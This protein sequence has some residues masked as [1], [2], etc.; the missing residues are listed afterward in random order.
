MLFSGVAAR[1]ETSIDRAASSHNFSGMWWNDPAGSE[2]GWGINIAHQGDVMFVTWLTYDLNGKAWWLSMTANRGDGDSYAGILYETRGP[3]FN[4][5]PFDP[6]RVSLT[7]VGTATLIFSDAR[8]GAFSYTVNGITQAKSIVLQAFADP[9]PVCTFGATSGGASSIGATNDAIAAT[10]YQDIWWNAPAN[11]EAG[12]GLNLTHQGNVIFAV[13][14]T[15]ELDGTPFWRSATL[16]MNGQK[17][18]AGTL[19]QTT[20]PAWNAVPFD[21]QEV[22]QT[23]VGTASLVFGDGNTGAF[24]YNVN[25]VAQTKIITREVL[26]SPGTVCH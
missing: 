6:S 17:S 13:W 16:F 11:S 21:S 9:V 19:Y 4:S 5:V 8:S 23:P 15:Y 3:A 7:P 20:G 24:S 14:F 26:R 25:G 1:A 18:Y 2:A 22:M 10:N 12:W